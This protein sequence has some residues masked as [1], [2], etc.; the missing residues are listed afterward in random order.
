MAATQLNFSR[1]ELLR[2]HDY[3]R[4]QVVAG[5]RIHGGFDEDGR[6]IPPRALVREPAIESWTQEL[7]SRGGELLAA[8]ASLLDGIRY[9]SAGQLK[10]LVR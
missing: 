10:L 9:P 7:R 1:E 8:D 2:S 3:A 4:P 5:Q 6:Y